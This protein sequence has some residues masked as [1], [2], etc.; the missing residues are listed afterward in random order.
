VL[1]PSLTGLRQGQV[2]GGSRGDDGGG[3]GAVR[4]MARGDEGAAAT[5]SGSRLAPSMT[6]APMDRG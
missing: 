5:V 3:V 1:C 4:A 2:R 6:V